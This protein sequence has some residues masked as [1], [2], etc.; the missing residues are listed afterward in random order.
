MTQQLTLVELESYDA[1]ARRSGSQRRFLCPL[2]G[3]GKPRDAAHRSL[4]VNSCTG[5]W[6]C[7]RCGARGLLKE[8][9]TERPPQTRRQRAQ[10]ELARAFALPPR[11]KPPESQP[12]ATEATWRGWWEA[13]APLIHRYGTTG[14]AY[15][16]SRGIA[17]DVAHNA[18]ARYS[19]NFYG[20]RAVL[21]PI[22][23]RAGALVALN[24]RF[25]EGSANPKTQ[26]AGKKSNG[27]F[28]T[29]GALESNLI[30]VC[31]GPFD[32]LS[33][34]LCGIPAIA[35]I[36]T[37]WPEWLPSALAFRSVL[38]ATDADESGDKAA[39][40]LEEA[41][42]SRGARTFRLRPRGAKDW[43]E[44]LVRRGADALRAHLAAFAST[45]EDQ[46]REAA[47]LELARQGRTQAA[48]FVASL[49]CETLRREKLKI[50]LRNPAAYVQPVATWG[51]L[52]DEIVIP[53]DMPNDEASIRACIDTQRIPA[54]NVA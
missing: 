40:T 38:I 11:E 44:I 10:T 33:L 3:D 18:E 47:A 35:L 22:T 27:V 53:A 32:A 41:L 21:F 2:C 4:A 51:V 31:E 6:T 25:V 9:W 39:S 45:T 12:E 46:T 19:T 48:Q 1:G 43:S 42:L 15:V 49:I 23:D 54:A 28:A 7:H 14:A 17:A 50:I 8:F 5:A 26:T 13:S 20:R 34:W 52:P 16:E 29:P 36:G 37:S 30:A 24:G